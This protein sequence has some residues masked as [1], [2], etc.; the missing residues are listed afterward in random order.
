ML[1]V[2]DDLIVQYIQHYGAHATFLWNASGLY[3]F[4]RFLFSGTATMTELV[5]IL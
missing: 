2:Q 3:Q 5:P 4:E 1:V